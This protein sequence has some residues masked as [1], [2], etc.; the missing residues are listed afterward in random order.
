MEID[1]LSEIETF[2]IYNMCNIIFMC[3]KL[4]SSI[5]TINMQILDV[6]IGGFSLIPAHFISLLLSIARG[7]FSL[8]FCWGRSTCKNSFWYKHKHTRTHIDGI[9]FGFGLHW[10]VAGSIMTP[11]PALLKRYAFSNVSVF[12]T[13]FIMIREWKWQRKRKRIDRSMGKNGT[14][15]RTH[16]WMN[17]YFPR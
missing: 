13:Y 6:D 5:H 4:D 7:V 3:E 11:R 15:A 8:H 9:G 10:H 14:N 1:N 17:V 16:L 2:Y 12:K